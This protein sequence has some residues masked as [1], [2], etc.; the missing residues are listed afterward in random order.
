MSSPSFSAN[1]SLNYFAFFHPVCRYCLERFQ[2]VELS[3]SGALKS[4]YLGVL[5]PV[6]LHGVFLG[7]FLRVLLSKQNVP[8]VFHPYLRSFIHCVISNLRDNHFYLLGW[9]S[10]E[11]RWPFVGK[12]VV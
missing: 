11:V 6:H 8:P 5:P 12:C 4:L 2:W 10:K 7:S 9:T 1:V 3:L